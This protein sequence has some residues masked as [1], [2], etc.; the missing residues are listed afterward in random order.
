MQKDIGEYMKLWAELVNCTNKERKQE[1]MK[2]INGV[3]NEKD[4]NQ[5]NA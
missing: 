5:N 1:I 2:Q 4:N 3:A